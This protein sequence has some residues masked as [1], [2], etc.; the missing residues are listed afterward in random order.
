MSEPQ[1][2]RWPLQQLI[3]HA[4]HAGC[5]LLIGDILM[6]EIRLAPRNLMA[7]VSKKESNKIDA[8]FPL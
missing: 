4:A 8:S 7:L 3:L 5:W 1:E 2:R 6:T